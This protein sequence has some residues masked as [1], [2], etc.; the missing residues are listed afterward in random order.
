MKSVLS[1]SLKTAAMAMVACLGAGAVLAETLVGSTVESRV[2]L[3]FKVD[4]AA[5]QSL[6]PEGWTLLTL[7]KGPVAGANV[8]IALMDRHV[9]LDGEGKPAAAPQNRAAALLSYA[10]N[11]DVPGVRTFITKVY[12]TPPLL[13]SFGNAVAAE[14][15]HSAASDA[16][17]AEGAMRSESWSIRPEGGGE[18]S[19]ELN[20]QAGV[21]VWVPETQS[22]PYSAANPDFSQIY[23]YAQLVDLA[24]NT[25]I[26]KP[27]NGEVSFSASDP[28]LG[29]M[30][31]GSEELITVMV[32]PVYYRTTSLP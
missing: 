3:G 26:G 20:Y 29:D 19:L 12:E 28:A 16:T 23:R 15:R 24:M 8:L 9:V 14:V 30:F 5:A 22:Q 6:L 17:G 31:D 2:L 11:P 32:I 4:D 7:P 18:I 13:N 27:L 10:I 21:P 1:R 25:Q